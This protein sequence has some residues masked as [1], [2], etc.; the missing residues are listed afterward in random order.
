MT[1]TRWAG[2]RS[3][4]RMSLWFLLSFLLIL[5]GCKKD[6]DTVKGNW[7]GTLVLTLT[8]DHE[9]YVQWTETSAGA[10]PVLH[11]ER[12]TWHFS[13]RI[14]ME[15]QFSADSSFLNTPINGSGTATQAP[16]FTPSSQLTLTALSG[17][18]FNVNVYGT[19]SSASVFQMRVTPE[20]NPGLTIRVASDNPY[21]QPAIPEYGAYV[22]SILSNIDL[23][24]PALDGTSIGGSGIQEVGDG[25]SPLAYIYSMTVNRQ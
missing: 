2:K 22:L 16:V 3:R 1:R 7:K 20:T 18:G 23:Q 12:V 9:E 17:A 14:V 4:A 10:A 8:H 5:P 13:D 15:F 24:V 6:E 21:I 19:I 11:V 25:G